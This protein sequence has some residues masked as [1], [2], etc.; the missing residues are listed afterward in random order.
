MSEHLA[1]AQEALER[2]MAN[3]VNWRGPC[4][5]CRFWESMHGK[6][7]R[8]RR[9]KVYTNHDVCTNELIV[10]DGFSPHQGFL[11]RKPP[12]DTARSQRG[13]CGHDGAFFEPYDPTPVSSLPEPPIK[14][15]WWK[16]FG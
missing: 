3:T 12:C 6:D 7:S 10:L 1:K 5:E 2:A 11:I 9:E 4:T 15:P 8:Y 14:R 13:L 16:I